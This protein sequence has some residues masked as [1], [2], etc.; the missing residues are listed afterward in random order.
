MQ[1]AKRDP[2]AEYDHAHGE[3]GYDQGGDDNG[4]FY[5]DVDE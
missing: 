1:R 3:R 4:D 5:D 2:K